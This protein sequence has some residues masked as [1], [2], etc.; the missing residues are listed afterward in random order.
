M[1]R[2]LAVA[3]VIGAW[4][5]AAT[6]LMAASRLELTAGFTSA[7]SDGPQN[8][9]ASLGAAATWDIGHRLWFGPMLFADDLGTEMGRIT[10]PVTGEDLGPQ[11]ESHRWIYGGAFR[12]DGELPSSGGWTGLGSVSW[13]YYRIEDDRVGQTLAAESALGLSL[14]AAV[15]RALK[16]STAI[17]MSARWHHLLTET[18]DHYLRVGVDLI[19]Q[20][21]A[22]L[23]APRKTNP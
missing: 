10:D 9:G 12:L 7:S 16:P 21:G 13:G 4:C 19:W 23:G 15:R 11:V 3:A 14:G 22:L 6:P 20:P 5:A 1:R 17:G 2:A 8:M 18:Q